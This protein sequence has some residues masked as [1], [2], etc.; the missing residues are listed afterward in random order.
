MKKIISS[1]SIV[2]LTAMLI[3]TVALAADTGQVTATVTASVVAVTV[4]DGAVAYGVVATTANT[5]SG[6]VND[7]QTITNT[8]TVTEDFEV[9]GNNS[10]SWTLAGSAG[11]ATY[12][13]KTCIAT[14]DST[15]TWTAMTVSYTDLATSKAPSGTTE[16]DV[17]ITVPTSNAG[18]TQQS[19][20]VDILATQ[21]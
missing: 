14:C 8:G 5:T 10:A 4:S 17:Q 21:S 6:G 20:P 15:P 3:G 12:A 11:N 13:H 2:S 19:V 18:V 1:I 16:M 7:T 9:K